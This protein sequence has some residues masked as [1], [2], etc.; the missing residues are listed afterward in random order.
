MCVC[1]LPCVAFAKSNVFRCGAR[2]V[3]QSW[4][5]IPTKHVYEFAIETKLELALYVN[6]D[7]SIN[8]E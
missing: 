6:R 5:D 3:I 2:G 4:C 1:V 7:Q 8:V